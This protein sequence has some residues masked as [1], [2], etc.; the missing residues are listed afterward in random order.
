MDLPSHGMYFSILFGLLF[1]VP[2]IQIS[3]MSNPNDITLS[4]PSKMFEYEKFSRQVDTCDDV[5]E[6]R[7]LLKSYYKLYL[8]Q[9]EV[10]SELKI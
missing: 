7:K 3:K 6:L 10:V 5:N 2:L 8:K 4:N 9:Q 1:L